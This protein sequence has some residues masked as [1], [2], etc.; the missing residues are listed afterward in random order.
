MAG[1]IR[2]KFAAMDLVPAI[3]LDSAKR[4]KRG[5]KVGELFAQALVH[6]AKGFA[7]AKARGARARGHAN[8]HPLGDGAGVAKEKLMLSCVVAVVGVDIK[9]GPNGI[10]QI[11]L[12]ILIARLGQA[13]GE[14]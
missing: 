8:A 13:M 14:G 1:E 3:P 9:V 10:A 2:E 5:R 7:G 12:N 4:P 11:L 6:P